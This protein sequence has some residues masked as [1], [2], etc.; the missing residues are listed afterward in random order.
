MYD[1]IRPFITYVAR[2]VKVRLGSSSNPVDGKSEC[3]LI[4]PVK[5]TD[6]KPED[7]DDSTRIN[8]GLINSKY[9]EDFELYGRASYNQLRVIL[10]VKMSKDGVDKAFAQLHEYTRQLYTEQHNLHFALGFTVCAGD[11]RLCHFG[12]SKAVSSNPMDVATRE[13]RRA[14]IELLINMLLCDD[15]QL[16]RDPTMHYL[17][18]LRCWQIDCPDDNDDDNSR[19]G[20]V[21]QYYFTNVIRIADR[22][23][24]RHTRCFLATESRPTKKLEEGQ[25][26]EATVVIKDAFAFAKPI[27]SEDDCDEVKTL[28]RIR[29]M[30]HDNNPD[31]ILYPKI[32]VGGRVKF[33]RGS[34][35]VEDTTSTIYEGVNDE[36]LKLV[37]SDSLF[38]A[39]QHIVMESIG[40][41]LRTVKTAKEFVAVICDAVQCHYAIVDKCKILHRDISNNNILVVRMKDSTVRG[42]LIDFDCAIDIS[43]DKKDIDSVSEARSSNQPRPT[44]ASD[45]STNDIGPFEMRSQEWEEISKDLLGVINKTKVEM[46]DWKGTPKQS[47]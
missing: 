45:D 19:R 30:F 24:D 5:L 37:S 40:E 2:H 28:K 11:V 44:P 9:N 17:S 15:S 41:P 14:F 3:R 4:H 18:E 8:I 7:S 38:H 42:L 20:E 16:G 33:R 32:V 31:D 13:G 36:L 12:P 1:P 27:S 10:E 26:L 22:L 25:S 43:R 47:Q 6:Y 46:S 21:A 34:Q 23:F 29:E 35:L 39:H